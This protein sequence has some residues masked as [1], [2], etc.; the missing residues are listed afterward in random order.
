MAQLRHGRQTEH[1]PDRQLAVYIGPAV[2]VSF[3]TWSCVHPERAALMR[4][5]TAE[6]LATSRAVF[7]G[8]TLSPS[9]AP[10]SLKGRA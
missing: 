5:T 1:M 9:K 6:I 7:I 2:P 10:T 3:A 4:A 8:L